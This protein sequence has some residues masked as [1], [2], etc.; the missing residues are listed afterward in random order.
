MQFV[1]VC[2]SIR[3]IISEKPKNTQRHSETVETT[4]SETAAGSAD[5]KTV[6][7]VKSEKIEPAERES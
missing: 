4:E 5:V 1:G 6:E 7:T 3:R 2:V